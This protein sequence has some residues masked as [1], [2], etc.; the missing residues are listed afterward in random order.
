MGSAA[1]EGA[2]ASTGAKFPLRGSVARPLE[3][4][5]VLL[6]AAEPVVRP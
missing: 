5:L 3:L 2:V 4:G 6:L 1:S